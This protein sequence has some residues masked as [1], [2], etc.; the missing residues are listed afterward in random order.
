[1]A[2]YSTPSTMSSYR[3][4]IALLL[5]RLIRLARRIRSRRS[6]GFLMVALLLTTA[7]VGNAVCFS[8]FESPVKPELEWDDCVWYSVVS[9][10]TIGCGD[11][12]PTTT[13][14]RIGTTFFI[15]LLGL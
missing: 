14:A 9:I 2:T 12:F 6:I 15:V 8:L 11:F 5:L 7:M 10:A 1:M 13:G 4:W 3:L